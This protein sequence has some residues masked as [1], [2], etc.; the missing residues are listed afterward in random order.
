MDVRA[1]IILT[2]VKITGGARVVVWG[3]RGFQELALYADGP[4]WIPGTE[5]SPTLPAVILGHRARSTMGAVVP[6]PIN[7]IKE[8]LRGLV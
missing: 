4:D 1:N 5:Q 6:I 3:R 2:R 8:Q 7:K